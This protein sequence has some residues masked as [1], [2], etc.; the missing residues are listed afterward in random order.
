MS[1]EDRE[2]VRVMVADRDEALGS[3]DEAKI[4][5]YAA[6]YGEAASMSDDPLVFW[7]GVHFARTNIRTLPMEQRTL[8][9]RWLR[10]HGAFRMLAQVPA[11]VP[12]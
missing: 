10:D 3:L 1:P 6:K 7:G 2:F 11:E 12:D 4:R 5:A 8:S 9:K